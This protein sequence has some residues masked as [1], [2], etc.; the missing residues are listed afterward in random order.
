MELKEFIKDVLTDIIEGVEEVRLTSSR[1]LR[2]QG[3]KDGRAVEFEIA[4]T[5]ENTDSSNKGGKV[6]VMELLQ[7]GVEKLNDQRNSSVSKINFGVHID[8]ITKTENQRTRH[9][10]NL[11]RSTRYQNE[12]F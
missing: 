7:I 5:V 6:K 3:D 12:A 4:V 2:I 11:N 10:N 1:D 8:S 9:E